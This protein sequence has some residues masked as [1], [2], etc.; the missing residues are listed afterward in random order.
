MRLAVYGSLKKSGKLHNR[1]V[2][3]GATF[4]G[5]S[6]FKGD[7][8]SLGA[9]PAAVE[10]PGTVFCEVFECSDALIARLDSIEGHPWHYRRQVVWTP[11]FGDV[12][13]YLYQHRLMSTDRK[14]ENG[15]YNVAD[16]K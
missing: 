13:A 2:E 7:L 10:G 4:L 8:F 15:R 12:Q 11:K 3:G 9:Y 6:T 14:I 16:W 5:E 1:M